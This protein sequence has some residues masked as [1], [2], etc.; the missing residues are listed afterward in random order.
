MADG[1]Q[2]PLL[3]LGAPRKLPRKKRNPNFPPPPPRDV[4]RHGRA[5]LAGAD[6]ARQRVADAAAIS[7]DL[8]TD[9]PYVRI[10][11]DPRNMVTDEGLVRMGLVPVM[12][13]QDHVIAAYATDAQL[14]TLRKKVGEYQRQTA[15]HGT[16][17]SI[18]TLG[19]WTRDD[20]TSPR[21]KEL[22]IA[23]D[24][25]YTVDLMFLPI[26]GARVAPGA[27]DAVTRFVQ[28]NGG[29]VLDQIRSAR[30]EALR[31]RL[32][33]QSLDLLLE[34]RAD[35]ALVDLPPRAHISVP[36]V[37]SFSIDDMP[38]PQPLNDSTPMVCVIDSGIVEGHPLL[39][40]TIAEKH[41]KA[42]PAALGP[43]IP[44]A[45][46]DAAR[47]GTGV[48]G[49][50]LY[51]DI[52][53]CVTSKTFEPAASL[54]NARILDDNIELD[55]ERMPYVRQIVDDV[56]S[57]CRIFNLSLG[58]EPAGTALSSYASDLDA[59]ARERDAIFIVS[60]GNEP[61]WIKY[62]DPTQLP[63]H[64]KYLLEEGMAVR[65]PAEALNV[66]TVGSITTANDPHPPSTS[67]R[68]AAGKRASSPFTRAGAIRNVVKPDLVEEGGEV[69]IDTQLNRWALSNPGLRIPTTGPEFATGKVFTYTDGTSIAA[70]KVAYFVAR[71]L[72]VMPDASANLVRALLVNSAGFPE[73]AQTYPLA[74][75]MRLCG[76][77]VPNLNRALF[78]TDARATAYFAGEIEIDDVLM[79][80]IHVPSELTESK[81][82]KRITVTVT[83]DPPVSA[84]E[85]L[86][87]AGINLTWK[88]AKAN[89]AESVIEAELVAAAEQELAGTADDEPKEKKKSK[90]KVF[91]AGKLPRRAQQ[92]GT[93]QKNIFEWTRKV[94]GDTWRL[95]L[96]AKATR[97]AHANE[98]QRFAV[99]V[100][101][102]HVTEPVA[103][104]QAIRA[105]L[106]AGR[107][108][109]RVPASR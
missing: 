51:G 5:L 104:Y 15:K 8:A 100:T 101:I 71:I 66:L 39:A 103:L 34:H 35:V 80:D 77:G 63:D 14:G 96:T 21:L 102:E 70:P 68:G 83:Y 52:A 85:Q 91:E 41:S 59:L 17:S 74:Q 11:H 27:R 36:A 108:R 40:H 9:V 24:G 38:D 58:L 93:V 33:G 31:V 78:C 76:F 42:Y 106:P 20:R 19:P 87:P 50:T 26:D 54:I 16:L 73:G 61:P 49:V 53:R 28:A 7:R 3:R 75:A 4:N 45:G 90:K 109:V 55:P 82:T 46:T 69:G 57:I 79:F 89:V 48:A 67:I 65:Q 22:S 47:H 44:G 88:V 18:A 30:F 72:G 2:Y 99:A 6:L 81:G 60:A 56:G 10:Q 86:R 98:K 62:P 37:L 12:H 43:P 95:A 1:D 94:P 97:P 25:S 84:L 32:G 23:R 107:V 29:K 92:R 105:R 13:R 64:P